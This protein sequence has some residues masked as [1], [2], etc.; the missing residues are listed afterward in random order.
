MQASHK[1]AEAVYKKQQASQQ[2][3]QPGSGEQPSS[4]QSRAQ[5][6]DK[7]DDGVVDAEF[8]VQDD[9]K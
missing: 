5:S 2:A 4:E 7:K 6:G 8:K 3:Q 1:L 9:K